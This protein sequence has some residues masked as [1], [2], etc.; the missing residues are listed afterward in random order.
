MSFSMNM[1]K[2]GKNSN[3]NIIKYQSIKAK[4]RVYEGETI[5]LLLTNN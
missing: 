5:K 1:Q 3:G 4:E 2:S